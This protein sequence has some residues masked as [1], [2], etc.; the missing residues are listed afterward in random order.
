MFTNGHFSR[1]HRLL[2]GL[3]LLLLAAA[4][5]IPGITYGQPDMA[6]L[7]SYVDNQTL[8]AN[9]A[10]HP[11]EFLQVMTPLRMLLRKQ[12]HPHFFENP[13]FLINLNFVTYWLTNAEHG[14][15]LSDREHINGTELDIGG[16]EYAPFRLYV[17]TH[18]FSALGGVLAV[19]GAF[20]LGRRLSK[21][22]VPVI[23]AGLL[24]AVSLPMVQHA[25]YAT[26]SSLAAGFAAASAWAALAALA[27][28]S[29]RR[30]LLALSGITAG[31]AAGCRYNAAA[32]SLVVFFTGII[33]LYRS[34]TRG[35]ARQVA[36]GWL[37]FPVS[38]VL[39]TPYL[40]R[41][42]Q[43]FIED[44]QYISNQYAGEQ[45]AGLK[46]L[47]LFYEFRYLALLGL[48]IP[49]I[50]LL[51]LGIGI[52]LLRQRAP[53]KQN[54]TALQVA[55]LLSFILPY[56]Y[57]VLRTVRP[58]MAEQMLVPL[59]PV[60]ASLIG[61]G[62]VWAARWLPGAAPLRGGLVIAAV[63]AMPLTV[64]LPALRLFTQTDTRDQM[65]AW[66]TEHVP[67]GTVIHLN[68]AYNVALDPALF[69]HT[70]NYYG[71][72]PAPD[73]LRAEGVELV[74]LS[75][76]L[77]Y[78]DLLNP[79][80]SPEQKELTRDYLAL[81][82]SLPILIRLERPTWPGYDQFMN[83]MRIWHHPGLTLY[84]LTEEACGRTA[85]PP[86]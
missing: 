58:N 2:A 69:P 1:S 35:M 75:D 64:T 23:T 7:P 60:L 52:P 42:P 26:T 77:L 70:Q 83:S 62:A 16:R 40:M 73:E 38:F 72:Y 76:A 71:V 5:R 31:L 15:T 20:G 61:L 49:A 32:I 13:N 36:L 48:G 53:L 6:Y 78:D 4:L 65:T 86:A 22:G 45:V 54:S 14:L 59:I 50:G 81:W 46:W 68:G 39:T 84:C 51:V 17:Q 29:R 21:R 82:D 12:L 74:L 80:V 44:L 33:L 85:S 11:D 57:V 67:A 79:L 3:L 28:P 27:S 66:I 10:F 43:K 24:T 37:L 19:A 9:S 47:G 18:Y 8:T 63:V 25:H 30:S 34:R 55:L 41:D 56:S